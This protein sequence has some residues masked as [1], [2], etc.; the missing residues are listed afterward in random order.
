MPNRK[1]NKLT[2]L[3]WVLGTFWVLFIIVLFY[4]IYHNKKTTHTYLTIADTSSIH[5]YGDIRGIDISSYQ[6]EIDWENIKKS[7]IDSFPIQFCLIKATEGINDVDYCFQLNW[8]NCLKNHIVRGAYLYFLSTKS[9]IDQ[10]NNYIKTVSLLPGDFPPIVDIEHLYGVPKAQMQQELTNCLQTLI[11]HYNSIPIIYSYADFYTQ[12]LGSDFSTY[13][14]W[15]AHYT[16]STQKL[17]INRNWTIWQYNDKGIIP[18]IKQNVDFD[19]FN[20]NKD[21]LLNFLIK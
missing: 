11:A 13:P 3:F 14:L 18:G 8:A 1:K 12:N 16:N 19:I 21:S 5:Y 15:I 2:Y 4:Y 6:N 7:K 10:A 20:G 17:H 9:G